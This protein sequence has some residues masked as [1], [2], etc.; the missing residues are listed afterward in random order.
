MCHFSRVCM[1]V[2]SI[3]AQFFLSV[4]FHFS[5]WKRKKRLNGFDGMVKNGYQQKWQI[6]NGK[7]N[8][9]PVHDCSIYLK[10]VFQSFLVYHVFEGVKMFQPSHATQAHTHTLDVRTYLIFLFCTREAVCAFLSFSHMR[11]ALIDHSNGHIT[12]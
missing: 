3:C 7:G 11:D 6:E 2:R 12:S 8:W 9:L 10:N 4:A 5:L 1:F